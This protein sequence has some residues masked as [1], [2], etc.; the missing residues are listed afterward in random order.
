LEC[1]SLINCL[2]FIVMVRSALFLSILLFL[3][4]SWQSL[5]ALALTKEPKEW[6]TEEVVHWANSIWNGVFVNW[7]ETN[8]VSGAL[9]LALDEWDLDSPELRDLSSF[10]KKKILVEIAKLRNEDYCA[11]KPRKSPSVNDYPSHFTSLLFKIAGNTTLARHSSGWFG[12]LL[13]APFWL[14]REEN[15]LADTLLVSLVLQPHL[16]LIADHFQNQTFGPIA[17]RSIA[18]LLVA[19][20][21]PGSF[22]CWHAGVALGG[23]PRVVRWGAAVTGFVQ[24]FFLFGWLRSGQRKRLLLARHIIVAPTFLLLWVAPLVWFALPLTG[25]FS[26]ALMACF[27]VGSIYAPFAKLMALIFDEQKPEKDQAKPIGFMVIFCG[28]YSFYW[29]WWL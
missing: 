29:F 10:A 16:Y 25:P 14:H 23:L 4:S 9:L 22:V 18:N 21:S 26:P 15:R 5:G 28:I 11:V 19:F 12:G 13:E 2:A 27:T 17:E 6:T 1:L 20:L 3:C 24:V 8:M 7:L